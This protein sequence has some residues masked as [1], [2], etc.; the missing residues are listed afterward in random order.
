MHYAKAQDRLYQLG[1]PME[2]VK[3]ILQKVT[4]WSQ[5]CGE[6][7]TVDRLKELKLMYIRFQSGLPINP[8]DV[9]IAQDKNGIPKGPFGYLFKCQKKDRKIFNVL[10]IYTSFTCSKVTKK[11]FNKFVGSLLAPDIT[12]PFIP[13][14]E[15]VAR[16]VSQFIPM[17]KEFTYRDY[18]WSSK[19]RAPGP[20]GTSCPEHFDILLEDFKRPCIRRLHE[21]HEGSIAYAMGDLYTRLLRIPEDRTMVDG[22]CVGRIAVVQEPGCKARFLAN[23]CRILQVASRPLGVQLFEALKHLPW[24]CTY[25]QAAGVSWVKSKLT[26]GTLVHSVDLSDATNNF[27]L[28]LQERFLY[29]LEGLSSSD[30][31]FLCSVAKSPWLFPKSLIPSD[32]P[33][34]TPFLEFFE[35]SGTSGITKVTWAKGQPLGLYPSFAMFAITHGSLVRSIELSMGKEDTFRVLGDD[36]VIAD[37]D[38]HDKYL[39]LLDRLQIPI[40]Q[41]KSISSDKVAEFAGVLCTPSQTLVGVKWRIPTRSNRL[42]L[43]ASLPR[44]LNL[45]DRE[46]FLGYLMR[47]A[48]PPYGEGMNPEGL[49]LKQRASLYLPWYLKHQEDLEYSHAERLSDAF[50]R[51]SDRMPLEDLGMNRE[52]LELWL[53]GA[54]PLPAYTDTKASTRD[55]PIPGQVVWNRITK[56][57]GFHWA[58]VPKNFGE[59]WYWTKDG[60]SCLNYLLSQNIE[61]GKFAEGMHVSE[62]YS[63]VARLQGK[64]TRLG[65]EMRQQLLSEII[66]DILDSECH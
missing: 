14:L 29:W 27:P 1:L 55:V 59:N 34:T 50:F 8:N 62:Y 43:I 24:D 19:R 61:T 5:S 63:K 21:E 66:A 52:D 4:Q 2:V 31:D 47:S 44:P 17:R 41:G 16:F 56:L 51:Y 26:S 42:K 6:E 30:I 49:S 65:P 12:L 32:I 13:K 48:P 54:G 11:Q 33:G 15:E 64:Y 20:N 60:V 45:S 38:V 9:W 18:P 3:P 23:P 28:S 53:S 10:L 57:F 35:R 58:S 25:N 39:L 36:I 7:W 37:N 46:E 40:S 22:D